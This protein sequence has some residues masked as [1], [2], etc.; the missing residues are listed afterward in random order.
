MLLANMQQHSSTLF[1]IFINDLAEEIKATK[2]G[3]NLAEN[4]LD[5]SFNDS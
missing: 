1:S 5:D 3:I 2:I 4:V